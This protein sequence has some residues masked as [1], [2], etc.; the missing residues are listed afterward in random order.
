MLDDKEEIFECCQP[1]GSGTTVI[2][3]CMEVASYM[4]IRYNCSTTLEE[5]FSSLSVLR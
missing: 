2:T 5:W 3:S 1:T 4:S